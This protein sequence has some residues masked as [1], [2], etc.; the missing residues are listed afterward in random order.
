MGR[1]MGWQGLKAWAVGGF[2]ARLARDT[3]ANTIA[4]VA[5]AMIPLCGMIGGGFDLSRMYIVKT[6]LQ[7]ACDAGALAGRKSMG[8]GTWAQ[9]SYMP[10]QMA[11]RF[12][13]ANIQA[14]AYGSNTITRTFTEN[15]GKVSGTASAVLPMTLMRV[16]G[17]TSETLS[18]TCETEMRLPNTDVMFVLDTTGSMDQK[19]RSSDTMK[20]IDG[21]KL[22]VRCF[23]E[24]VARLDTVANC[25][26]GA[27][28]GGTG[29]QVQIRFGFVPYSTNVNVGKLL[30][31]A[32]MA[33]EGMY[34]TRA[35]L[36]NSGRFRY[37]LLPVNLSGMKNGT[38]YNNSFDV[39]TGPNKG[40]TSTFRVNW[41]GCIEERQTAKTTDY[42]PIPSTALDLD[43]DTAPT[44]GNPATQWKPAL[45]EITYLRQLRTSWT[46]LSRDNVSS[47]DQTYYR[48]DQLRRYYCPTEA[49]LLQ[50]WPDASAFDNYVSSLT[51]VGNTYHDIGMI[52]GARLMSPDGMYRA[53]NEFTPQGGEIERH[54]IFMT[55]GDA[56]STNCDYNAYGIHF[57]DR[58]QTDDVGN[59]SNCMDGDSLSSLTSQ[60]N[61]RLEALCDVVK[62]KNITL[63]VVSFGGGNSEDTEDRL[64][65]CASPGRY[66]LAN[67]SAALQRTFKSI[68]DQISALRLIR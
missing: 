44:P 6:R 68:A 9:S 26:G 66:F 19:A 34:N 42:S 16:L 7:H 8:G 64:E 13:D 47:T 33:D 49:R 27:P 24:I 31:N 4:I 3:R 22:A 65:S 63:W 37:D 67:D 32:W 46:E 14:D 35:E 38:G 30:P 20:K 51:P 48:Y 10:R 18:V 52:W 40:V 36:G 21:L 43:V 50:T 60:I 17:K 15:A 45:P 55:D 59:W 2:L 54:M 29:S 23:Y 56:V 28:S 57:Y 1:R 58:R 61:S 11:E 39:Q 25:D 53:Q 41:T 5:A 12:F 62:N